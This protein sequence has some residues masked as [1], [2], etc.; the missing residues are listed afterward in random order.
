MSA[1]QI[2]FCNYVYR[3]LLSH[4]S[5]PKTSNALKEKI[6][7]SLAEL[8]S[9]ANLHSK[10]DTIATCGQFYPKNHEITFTIADAG[11]GIHQNVVNFYQKQGYHYSQ[12]AGQSIE[13]AMVDGNTTKNSPGGSGLAILKEFVKMNKGF[14]HLVSGE[15]C[16]EC[17][18]NGEFSRLFYKPFPGTFA[19]VKFRTDDTRSYIL[20]SENP[21]TLF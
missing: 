10:S 17:S 9:N 7:E 2:G 13:W 19:T 18:E 14:I 3:E 1:D 8:F 12:N 11:I 4:H 15:G 21:N 20:S 6:L 16:Y 5:F